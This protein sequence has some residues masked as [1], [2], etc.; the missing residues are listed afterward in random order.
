MRCKPQLKQINNKNSQKK[1]IKMYTHKVTRK[2]NNKKHKFP[3][4]LFLGKQIL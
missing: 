3:N 4:D 1:K 2:L